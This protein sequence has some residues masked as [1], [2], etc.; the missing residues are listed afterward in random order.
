MGY[1]RLCSRFYALASDLIVP[2]LHHTQERYF[3]TVMEMFPEDAAWLEI[4]CGHQVF[5]G[6]MR[7]QERLAAD[8]SQTF[9]GVDLDRGALP[10]HLTLDLKAVARGENLPFFSGLFDL[11]T[12]NMVVEHI[13]D[14]GAVFREVHRVLRPGGLF[15]IHTTNH[16]SWK[17]R[18][19][20]ALPS[21]L[22]NWI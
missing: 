7:E 11:V 18:F 13:E 19:A 8:R 14:P 21:W 2:G 22:K 16:Q 3:E 17:I 4:G 20:S 12:A 15:L 9:V 1:R 5:G 10:H 6:W